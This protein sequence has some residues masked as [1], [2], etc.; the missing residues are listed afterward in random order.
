[1]DVHTP[2]QRS[3]NMSRIRGKDTSPEMKVRHLLHSLGYRYRLHVRDLPGCPDIVLPKHR[4]L[5]FVHG[6]FW[7]M[8][9]CRFGRVVPKTNTEFWQ[10]KRSGNTERD[11]RNAKQLRKVGWTV[12]TVW[13]C[14]TKNPE[15][16]KRRLL[17]RFPN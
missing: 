3:F 2:K 11:R 1:M 14:E 15:T 8:H 6:C 7:H 17:L 9:K 13:E 16:L 5:I 4:V 10:T 12:L